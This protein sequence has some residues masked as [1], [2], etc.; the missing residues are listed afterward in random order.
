MKTRMTLILSALA[1]GLTLLSSPIRAEDIPIKITG[2]VQVPPCK[3]NNNTDFNVPFG[4]ISLQKVDG[5]NYAQPTTVEVSCEYFK[6]RPYIRLSGGTGQLS[7]APDNVLKT[8]GANP[9]TLGIALYQGDSVD[10]SSPL[11]IGAG[12]QG[13]LGYEIKKGLSASNTQK[14]QFT[15]TAVPYKLGSADLNAGTFSASITMSISYQ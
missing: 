6:G 11:K 7:G 3:I 2:T 12:E 15:F 10:T 5:R 1:G 9:E 14:S 13:Q 4:K 8:T